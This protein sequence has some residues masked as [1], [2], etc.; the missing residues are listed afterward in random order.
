VAVAPI[1]RHRAG[2]ADTANGVGPIHCHLDDQVNSGQHHGFYRYRSGVQ[3]NGSYE[4][5]LDHYGL[6]HYGFDQ[7]EFHHR[8]PRRPGSHRRFGPGI[9]QDR[10]PS[11]SGR[12]GVAQRP[13]SSVPTI[14]RSP[15]CRGV[16][17]HDCG[18]TDRH[19]IG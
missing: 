2:G 5:G 12:R 8:S 9:G 3:V 13:R 10:S 15:E 17:D 18:P 14:R 6:D 7:Y 19:R 1:R 4:R 16:G 11:H